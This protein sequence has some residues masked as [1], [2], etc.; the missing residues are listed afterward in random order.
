MSDLKKWI[1]EIPP[2]TRTLVFGSLVVTLLGSYGFVSPSTIALRWSPIWERFEIWRLVLNFFF[3]YKLGLR[4]IVRMFALYR[5]GS[6]LEN[7]QFQGRLA[8]LVWMI[9]VG[10][11]SLTVINLYFG[12]PFLSEGI[13]MMVIYYW[14]RKNPSGVI[15]FMLGVRTKSIYLPW[16]MCS[17]T[18][19]IERRFPLLELLGMWQARRLVGI[20]L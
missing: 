15:T 20:F 6:S 7:K 12:F 5:Y 8:D 4:F 1:S 2:V 3:H 14:S 9:T 13:V 17:F 16:I 11:V 18:L 10:C 19:I